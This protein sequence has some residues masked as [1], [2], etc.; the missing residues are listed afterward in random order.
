MIQYCIIRDYYNLRQRDDKAL[1]L[2][3]KGLIDRWA[4]RGLDPVV[5][6][7]IRTGVFNVAAP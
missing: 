7:D 5:L 4:A 2:E 6:A 1:V 3:A